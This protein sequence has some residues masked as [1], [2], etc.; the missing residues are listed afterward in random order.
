MRIF[1]RGIIVFLAFITTVG[2]GMKL[3][4]T[5]DYAAFKTANGTT[6]LETYLLVHSYSYHLKKNANS[7]LTGDIEVAMIFSKDNKISHFDKYRITTGELF[8]I[9]SSRL[10]IL[11]LKRIEMPQ[12][13]YKVEL[14]LIDLNSENQSNKIEYSDSVMI[15]FPMDKPSFSYLQL[16]EKVENSSHENMFTKGNKDLY[17]Q[18]NNYFDDKYDQL[19]FYTE[20]YDTDKY[21]GENEKYIVQY[22]IY[23]FENNLPVKNL[24]RVERFTGKAIQPILAGINL[25]DL[26]PGNY[27]LLVELRDKNNNVISSVRRFFQR[28]GQVKEPDVTDLSAIGTAFMTYVNNI[29][30]LKEYIQCLRPI[31]SRS[32]AGYGNNVIKT[33]D[34]E[35]M[36]R[37]IVSF[38]LRRNEEE[39]EQ[40]WKKYRAQVKAADRLFNT[41]FLRSYDTDRGRVF[42]QYGPPNIRS[43]RPNE[44]NAYPYEIWQYYKLNNQTN[45]V[46][47]FWNKEAATN[48]YELL[49]SDALGERRV[50]NWQWW[51]Q[52]RG[53][54]PQDPDSQRPE[55]SFG[56]MSNDLL[57]NPR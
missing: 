4:A 36:K 20:V 42:L 25:K 22:G 55:S 37:Y 34:R 48:N 2:Y 46:F 19:T 26:S 56:N 12:G 8:Q 18:L 6:F 10:N 52:N 57:R 44:P 35:M 33:K 1:Q 11:D 29:D 47:V 27:G 39:P 40:E 53:R 13:K 9:D 14:V 49:H 50:E 16:I 45:R 54:L 43:E 3:S 31:A 5:F 21:L 32:E 7:S 30:T 51:I 41:Q 28:A 23:N 38:W 24:M 17:P 15:Y